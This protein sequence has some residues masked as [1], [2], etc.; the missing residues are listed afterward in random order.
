MRMQLGGSHLDLSDMAVTIYQV[1]RWVGDE[2]RPLDEHGQLRL[3]DVLT[4][5]G[6]L[7]DWEPGSH[8]PGA[9]RP[10]LK[11]SEMVDIAVHVG[12]LRYEPGRLLTADE[13][14]LPKLTTEMVR[15]MLVPYVHGAAPGLLVPVAELK[16]LGS[17]VVNAMWD[18]LASAPATLA[19]EDLVSRLWWNE[20][21]HHVKPAH[22]YPNPPIRTRPDLLEDFR[23]RVVAV[24]AA[25][26]W[27]GLAA[28]DDECV[29]VA[30]TPFGREEV[31]H[32]PPHRLPQRRILG[33]LHDRLRRRSATTA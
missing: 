29:R 14:P 15:R 3:A 9:R 30:L 13:Q 19:V 18:E 20:V 22:L 31:H 33:R 12:L 23:N 1:V 8:T 21:D 17:D 7:S 25:Y 4:L 6:Q 28:F 5:G 27:V 26:A 16:H 2:G 32:L 11:V 24:L 10:P